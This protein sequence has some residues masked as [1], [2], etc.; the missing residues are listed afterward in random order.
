MTV[1]FSTASALRPDGPRAFFQVPDDALQAA[2]VAK[3]TGILGRHQA[4]RFHE[5]D[6]VPE[7][8]TP[9]VLDMGSDAQPTPRHGAEAL[10]RLMRERVR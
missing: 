2:V 9:V 6:E 1:I 7:G 8:V 3:V 10:G 5:P 4:Y